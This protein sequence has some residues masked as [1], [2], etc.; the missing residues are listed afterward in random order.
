MLHLT[1]MIQDLSGSVF[2]PC[3]RKGLNSVSSLPFQPESQVDPKLD[4]NLTLLTF[5]KFFASLWLSLETFDLFTQRWA[6]LKPVSV[7][8]E[9]T[10]QST[11]LNHPH[12]RK[13]LITVNPE[14]SHVSFVFYNSTSGT[15]IA[16]VSWEDKRLIFL[17]NLRS[18]FE[19]D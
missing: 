12:C 16:L 10:S 13:D 2:Y 18:S 8:F 15:N 3:Y 17:I 6:T 19:T 7:R 4:L 14:I 9:L 11:A 1:K 5:T